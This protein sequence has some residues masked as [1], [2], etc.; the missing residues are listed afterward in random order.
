MSAIESLDLSHNELSGPIPWE[1]TRLWSLE[2][3]SVAYNY[4]SGCIPDSGQFAS[5]TMDSYQGN[6]NLKNMSLRNGC[7]A[8]SGPIAPPLEDESVPSDPILYVVSAS[9]FVLAFWV[10]IAFSFCH[11]YGRSVILNM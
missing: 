9:S 10:T 6:K 2:V 7:S 4:L 1:L 8:A 11:S 5:F 3:F